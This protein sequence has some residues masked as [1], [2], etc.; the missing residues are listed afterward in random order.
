MLVSITLR[1]LQYRMVWS[2]QRLLNCLTHRSKVSPAPHSQPYPRVYAYLWHFICSFHSG[3]CSSLHHLFNKILLYIGEC[4]NNLKY[5]DKLSPSTG[6]KKSN[7]LECIEHVFQLHQIL[8]VGEGIHWKSLHRRSILEK[9][10]IL[11]SIEETIWVIL[12][13][14]AYEGNHAP[15]EEMGEKDW[16]GKQRNGKLLAGQCFCL[17]PRLTW[18]WQTSLPVALEISQEYFPAAAGRSL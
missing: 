10:N 18:A 16:G 3:E 13:K 1:L 11:S 17:L 7:R 6:C 9:K 2:Y 12:C 14:Q 15:S 4:K 5:S 8:K